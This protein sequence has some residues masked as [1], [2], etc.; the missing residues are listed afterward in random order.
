VIT[1]VFYLEVSLRIKLEEECACPHQVPW[2]LEETLRVKFMFLKPMKVADLSHSSLD[3]V[4]NASL[5]QL[6]AQ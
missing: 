2:M 6:I 3:I 1:L 5:E 4:H